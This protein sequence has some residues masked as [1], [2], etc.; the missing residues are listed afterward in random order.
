MYQLKTTSKSDA[1][2]VRNRTTID[3]LRVIRS[4][5]GVEV[6]VDCALLSAEIK[7][8]A[9][10]HGISARLTD[11]S[12]M[13]KNATGA[14]KLSA[15]QKIAEL[16][17]AGKWAERTASGNTI[18]VLVSDWETAA[19]ELLKRSYS[20]L[21]VAQQV[22]FQLSPTAKSHANAAALKRVS[23]NQSADASLDSLLASLGVLDDDAAIDQEVEAVE[24]ALY[25]AEIAEQAIDDAIL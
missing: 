21:T 4:M 16:L 17:L 18:I 1:L 5:E 3:G 25:A 10:L 14:S 7:E 11:A 12:A 9:M 8:K 15:T 6:I 22:Q 24:S 20:S 23:A 19:M 2:A 13:V